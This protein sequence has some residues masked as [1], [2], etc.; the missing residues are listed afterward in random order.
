MEQMSFCNNQSKM[1]NVMTADNC[2]NIEAALQYVAETPKVLSSDAIAHVQ[3]YVASQIKSWADK[4]NK[5]LSEQDIMYGL[6]RSQVILQGAGDLNN[7]CAVDMRYA[8]EFPT[9]IPLMRYG[10][11]LDDNTSVRRMA[12]LMDMLFDDAGKAK[13]ETQ[14]LFLESLT[15]KLTENNQE[16]NVSQQGMVEVLLNGIRRSAKE[17][18]GWSVF[19]MDEKN[20]SVSAG[21]GDKVMEPCV[22]VKNIKTIDVNERNLQ[23]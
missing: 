22:I 13:Y 8:V 15:N 20:K 14:H 11:R 5:R 7:A 23:R 12:F 18:D 9:R 19:S 16:K 21:A 10:V 2:K 3:R 17:C 6:I 4:S 1:C